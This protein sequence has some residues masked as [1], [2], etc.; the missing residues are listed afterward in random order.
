MNNQEFEK[1][2]KRLST[3]VTDMHYRWN[4]YREVF[5]SGDDQIKLIN[6]CGSNFFYIVQHMMIDQMSLS[7]SKLTDPNKSR[8][9]GQFVENL[10]LKQIHEFLNQSNNHELLQKIKPLYDELEC[11]CQNFRVLRNKRIAHGDLD[12]AME[13]SEQPLPSISHR[14][15][16]VALETLRNYMNMVDGS[17]FKNKTVYEHILMRSESGGRRLIEVLRKGI[18]A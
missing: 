6:Q 7:F 8:I 2:F 1:V 14:Y 16:E 3:E 11:N 17:L 4:L 9:R 13:A 5:A 15:I 18:N 10:S 12:H